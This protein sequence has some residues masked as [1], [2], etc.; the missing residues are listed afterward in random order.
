MLTSYFYWYDAKTKE[1]IID[2]DGSDAL[3]DHPPTLDGVSYRNPAWHRRQLEDMVHAGIDPQVF[4]SAYQEHAGES[5]RCY[6]WSR[7]VIG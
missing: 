5:I 7:P 2:H 1:H 4:A 6:N 3:T